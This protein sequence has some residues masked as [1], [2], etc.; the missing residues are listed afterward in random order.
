M[1]NEKFKP[2]V[3]AIEHLLGKILSP[4]DLKILYMIYDF[5][6]LPPEV[7][8]TLAGWCNEKAKKGGPAAP[9][10]CP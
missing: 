1:N 8:L 4:S 2:L 10:P 6:G 9:P 5:L 3:P 7:I